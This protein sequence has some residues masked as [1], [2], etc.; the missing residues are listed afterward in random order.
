MPNNTIRLFD[1]TVTLTTSL[2]L[3]LSVD[4]LVVG[5][6]ADVYAARQSKLCQDLERMAGSGL[7]QQFIAVRNQPDTTPPNLIWTQLIGPSE[8]HF[9][10]V[11]FA[12]GGLL[13]GDVLRVVRRAVWNKQKSLA[14]SLGIVD[15]K[16]TTMD[17]MARWVFEACCAY[18]LRTLTVVGT[19][20]QLKEFSAKLEALKNT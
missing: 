1:T 7:W 11:I 16:R 9:S 19:A 14:I 15:L 4:W 5:V 13:G 3:E 20:K 10:R 8:G 2:I 6:P 12:A 17:D 18:P